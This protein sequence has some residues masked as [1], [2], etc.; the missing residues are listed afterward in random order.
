MSASGQKQTCERALAMS[1]LPPKADTAPS[2]WDAHQ[3]RATS[4]YHNQL[5]PATSH[6][7]KLAPPIPIGRGCRRA[8]ADCTGWD[9]AK[10]QGP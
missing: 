4:R 3:V 1:A 2:A 8:L 10:G 6:A 5:I 7:L 9:S